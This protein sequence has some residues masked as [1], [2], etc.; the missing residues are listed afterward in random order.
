MVPRTSLLLWLIVVSLCLLLV[1]QTGFARELPTKGLLLWLNASDLDGDDRPDHHLSNGS[2]VTRWFDKSGNGNHVEQP[3]PDHQPTLEKGQLGGQ[4]VVRFHGDDLLVRARFDSFAFRD[5]PL[6]VIV[7]MKAREILSHPSPRLIEFQP[8]DGDLSQPKTVKQHGFW[9]GSQGDGR[10]HL[11][12]HYGDEGGALS[13][14]WDATPHVVEVIY[15]GAQHWVHYLDGQRD[16]AGLFGDRDFHGFTKDVRLAIG[17]QYG[18]ADSKS[19]FQGDLAEMLV[20]DRMLSPEEQ[21]TLKSYFS[22]TYPLDLTIE[23][24]PHFERDVLPI[25]AQH[26]HACHGG[27]RLESGVDLRTLSAMLRGGNGGPVISPGH[28]EF[29]ELLDQLNEGKMPPDGHAPVH[30]DKI[31]ILRNWIAAGTPADEKVPAT[32]GHDLVTEE[33]RQFWAYQPLAP[34]AVPRIRSNQISTPVDAFLLQKLN[35]LGLSFT[36]TADRITLI[37][38]ASF[39]LTGLPPAPD[40]VAAFL[41]DKDPDAFERLLDRLLSSV[42]FGERWGRCW[43]D[44][45]GYV[46]VHGKDNDFVIIKPLESR[47]RYRD[48]VIRSFNQDKPFHRFVL[49]QL[50][51]DELVDWR[52][53]EHFT[54]E[55]VELLTATGFLL[56]GPD[57]T[58]Q[59]ELNTPDIRHHVLQSTSQ[60]VAN[61]LFALTLQCAKCHDHKYEAIPQVDYYRW[62]ANFSP[63]FNPQRWVTTKEHAIP[64]VSR[65]ERQA[66]DKHN[67]EID[68]RIAEFTRQCEELRTPHRQRLLEAQLAT[69]PQPIRGD[70]KISAETLAENRTKIQKYLVEKFQRQITVTPEAIEKTLPAEDRKRISATEHVVAQLNAQKQ[71][72]GTIQ[73]AVEQSPPSPTYVL[74]R[75]ETT[76]PGVEVQPGLLSIVSTETEPTTGKPQGATSGRRL[77]MAQQITKPGSIATALVTRVYVNR[78]WQE[79]FGTGIVSTS[80]NFGVSGARPSHPE[81]LDWLATEF[82]RGGWKT[83]PLLKRIMMSSAYQQRSGRENVSLAEKSNPANTL[84]WQ[85]RLRRITSEMVRDRILA[86]SGQLNRSIGGSPVPLMARP[87][88]KI[89][90]DMKALP[91]PS[92]HLRRSM[93]ILNRR[94]YH[95]SMLATFDQPMLVTNCTLRKPAA[96][97]TQ[98]LTMLNDEFVLTQ[99]STFASRVMRETTDPTP[100]GHVRKAYHIALNRT[101]SSTEIDWCVALHQRHAERYRQSAITAAQAD[102]KALTHLC[103]MLFN[104]NEFL[105]LP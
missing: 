9:I 94:N 83:K 5:Q 55:T 13:V 16:G 48:Y 56:C 44:W 96:I 65:T 73:V 59:N 93:Y 101:P 45:S 57:D 51:G 77:A 102:Q 12:T 91:T 42:H 70:V 79:L 10:M 31:A 4:P 61:N 64:D 8:V 84:L 82:V 32:T 74:R 97:V 26:C 68:Q 87:D 62:Q 100:A 18:S 47:W 72:Y 95:L 88:G 14:A 103:H 105:Y 23:P 39:D 80:D 78:L 29:S 19:Y 104:T 52:N 81:L 67:S 58:S 89:I 53:V 36:E 27:D 28:P 35:P 20:Y 98:A 6:H 21:N 2:P 43:L 22:R 71:S 76:K 17:Q 37:R 3:H 41:A 75:G 40:E 1:A 34:G 25:L 85:T 90:V 92:S 86:T 99:A 15:G 24:V 49:E 54:P 50:A 11:G 7:V 30:P 60:I 33:D 66:I 69:I 46:D 38:R 63:V